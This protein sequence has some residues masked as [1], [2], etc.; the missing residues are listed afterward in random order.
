LRP[1]LSERLQDAERYAAAAQAQNTTRAY[2]SDWSKF[3][4]SCERYSLT[5]LPAP[6]RRDRALSGQPP[7]RLPDP[8]VFKRVQIPWW[9]SLTLMQNAGNLLQI[10]RS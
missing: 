6:G 8:W 4:G 2:A 10:V 7:T 1:E 9:D 3:E 5:T